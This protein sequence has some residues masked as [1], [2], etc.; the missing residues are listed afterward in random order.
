MANP[1]EGTKSTQEISKINI[2]DGIGDTT[3]LIT[4]NSTVLDKERLGLEL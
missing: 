3:N 4:D 2:P 1:N